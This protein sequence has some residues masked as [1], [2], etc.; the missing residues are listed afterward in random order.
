WNDINNVQVSNPDT[1]IPR[2]TYQDPN[3]NARVSDRYIED[4]SYVRVRTISL[5][6]NFPTSVT[7]KIK[8]S[9]LR[10]YAKVQNAFTFT[11]YSGYDP[12]VGQDTWDPLIYGLDNGRYP[13]PKV[14]TL[15]LSAN[16]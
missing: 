6:Y 3:Q 15:G 16:F 10:V 14:Y 7:S 1:D 2:A 13:S 4:G 12:E 11:K 8:I 5:A 9:N